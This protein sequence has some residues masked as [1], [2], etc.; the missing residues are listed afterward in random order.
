MGNTVK[1]RCSL[2]GS[3][4]VFVHAER[5]DAL[6][7][8][9][10]LKERGSVMTLVVRGPVNMD[11]IRAAGYNIKNRLHL[12]VKTNDSLWASPLLALADR[13]G[14]RA[15]VTW[16]PIV[17]GIVRSARVLEQIASMCVG[18]K[19][20]F[21][22]MFPQIQ[23]PVQKTADGWTVNGVHVDDRFIRKDRDRH[24]PTP[25]YIRR[26]MQKMHRYLDCTTYSAGICGRDCSGCEIEAH[27]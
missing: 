21:L 13:C 9:D 19:T 14:I 8:I 3:S 27:G 6:W 24:F 12:F 23:L 5:P 15:A 1:K 17:P 20:R 26:F 25:E 11:I 22:F 18:Y 7:C 4:D 16:Y 2:L 10:N